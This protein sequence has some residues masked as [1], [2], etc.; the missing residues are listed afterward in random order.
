MGNELSFK[1]FF[2]A[3]SV[4]ETLIEENYVIMLSKE[5]KS[6]ILNYE[7]S[8]NSDRNNIIFMD[9][10][11][12]EE[13]LDRDIYTTANK[14]DIIEGI[15]DYFLYELNTQLDDSSQIN[16]KY[17]Y[18][19]FESSTSGERRLKIPF[20]SVMTY[21]RFLKVTLEER[22]CWINYALVLSLI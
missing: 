13:E 18:L 4:A 6:Y 3:S 20:D 8:R 16:D 14:E 21:E 22:I 2:G 19:E 12:Y 11:E 10:E 1:D 9:K 5:E 17:L 15:R 7:W